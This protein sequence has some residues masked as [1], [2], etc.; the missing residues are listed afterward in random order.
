MRI[1]LVQ[2]QFLLIFLWKRV[3][4]LNLMVFVPFYQQLFIFNNKNEIVCEYFG[5]DY[6][7]TIPEILVNFLELLFITF[8]FLYFTHWRLRSIS[9]LKKTITIHP[10]KTT[11]SKDQGLTF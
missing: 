5:V 10:D 2:W 7:I 4:N 3:K 1:L 11:S 9:L 6:V 8:T